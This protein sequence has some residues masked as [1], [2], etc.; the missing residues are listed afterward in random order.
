MPEKYAIIVTTINH[1]TQ[2]VAKIASEA[3]NLDAQV[4]LVGDRKS[5]PDFHQVGATF[6]SLEDQLAS[7]FSFAAVAPIGHYARKNIGYLQAI[8]DGATVIIETDDDNFPLPSFW[9]ERERIQ[10]ATPCTYNG[11]VNVYG[12]FSSERKIWPRGLP[13]QSINDPLPPIGSRAL[14]DCPIQ[15]GLADSNPDV[16]AVYRLTRSLPFTFDLTA[17]ISLNNAWCPFNSQNTTWWRDAFPLLYLPS[18]CSFRMTDIWRSF[19]AQHIAYANGW[20][21]LFH[22]PT[23]YQERNEHSLIKDFEEE[24]PGY[25]HND[26]IKNAFSGIAIEPGTKNIEHGMRS[27][28][29]ALAS[30]NLV[31]IK[32]M[33][34]LNCWIADIK[35]L[36]S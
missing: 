23:V 29:Q 32:E 7:D 19:V 15:Q 14:I 6:M 17:N 5:P 4:I 31:D 36:Q 13:L 26:K 12:Y 35:A 16:D 34:L 3:I 18:F 10:Q 8:A 22:S 30:M 21:I 9:L 27:C 28:Y 2:A 24:V 11:W 20:S 25:L 1:P 33:D